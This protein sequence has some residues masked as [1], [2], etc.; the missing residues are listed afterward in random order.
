MTGV[1]VEQEDARG[2]NFLAHLVFLTQLKDYEHASKIT[3][4]FY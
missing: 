2:N 3:E 4:I 1:R